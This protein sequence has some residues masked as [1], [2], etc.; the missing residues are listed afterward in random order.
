MIAMEALGAVLI[1]AFLGAVA[2]VWW[3]RRLW[4]RRKQL[5]L[6]TRAVAVIV[7][8]SALVGA[9]GTLIGLVKASGAVGGESVDPSQKARILADGISE[10]MNCTAFGMVVWLPSV[11]LLVVMMR[12][13]EEPRG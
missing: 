9:L 1:V 5:P 13:R 12:R 11:I 8:A 10:A 4:R 3:A 6:R 7:V 2:T